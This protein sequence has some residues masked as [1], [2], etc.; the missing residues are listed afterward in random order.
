MPNSID[1]DYSFR[2]DEQADR[3]PE[4]EEPTAK[5]MIIEIIIN[6]LGQ[7]AM[8]TPSRKVLRWN[9]VHLLE[10]LD[11]YIIYDGKDTPYDRP[12]A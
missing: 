2:A 10:E 1:Y 3:E 4:Y 5:E 6:A 11:P 8:N 7:M 9:A 12:S